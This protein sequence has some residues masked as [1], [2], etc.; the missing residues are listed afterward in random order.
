MHTTKITTKLTEDLT[1]EGVSRVANFNKEEI[2]VDEV[3]SEGFKNIFLGS[4]VMSDVSDVNKWSTERFSAGVQFEEYWRRFLNSL[5][6]LPFA[7]K[8]EAVD[9][10]LH[11][12]LCSH[13]R[14]IELTGIEGYHYEE[15]DI[16]AIKGE[17]MFRFNE[18]V[19]SHCFPSSRPASR[20]THQ[21]FEGHRLLFNQ[22]LKI[23]EAMFAN[24]YSKYYT[25]HE[26]GDLF[27]KF[28]DD[29]WG[30]YEVGLPVS[31]EKQRMFIFA[32]DSQVKELRAYDSDI[33]FDQY[34]FNT[35]F[36]VSNG[37]FWNL[38][39]S[40]FRG[41]LDRTLNTEGDFCVVKILGLVAW[42]EEALNT[43]IERH[44]V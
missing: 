7:S 11:G 1:F 22:F 38:G 17:C 21:N 37:C 44:Y 26:P 43:Y 41:Q 29:K 6:G 30:L 32:L 2:I 12:V 4:K 31:P 33:I 23:G 3:F 28:L 36:D 24:E 10:F 42:P 20:Y 9:F 18:G 39:D 19:L 15:D 14:R 40:N 27:S 5:N 25:A 34:R 16:N 8:K 13:L 35:L